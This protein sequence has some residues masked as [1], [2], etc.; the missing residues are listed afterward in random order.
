MDAAFAGARRK[1]LG[2]TQQELARRSG[3]PQP[4]ISAIEGGKRKATPAATRA[5][6]Q[7]LRMSPAVALAQLRKEVLHIVSANHGRAAYVFGSVARQQDT[8]DSDLDLAVEFDEG[9]DIVDLL[10]ME[11][12]LEALLTVPVDVVSLGSSSRMTSE[13]RKEMVPL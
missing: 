8:S 6:E 5:L 12:E 9:A 13:L 7:A 10:T 1:L 3:V 11:E 4:L 2:L